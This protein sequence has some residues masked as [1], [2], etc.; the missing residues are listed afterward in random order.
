MPAFVDDETAYC[1]ESPSFFFDPGRILIHAP[2]LEPLPTHT[3][4][5]S[6]GYIRPVA[7]YISQEVDE[8]TTSHKHVFIICAA[9]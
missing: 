3:P 4:H 5:S 7:H 8:L 2:I 9:E 6:F 1:L